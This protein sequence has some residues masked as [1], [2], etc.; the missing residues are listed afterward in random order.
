MARKGRAP[1]RALL[2]LVSKSHPQ[3]DAASAIT[4]GLVLV[5]GRVA[6]NPQSL[7][8]RDASITIR[9]DQPL[10]GEA[11]LAAALTGFGVAVAGRVALDLGAAAGGFTRTL[12]AAG[13]ARVYAVDAGFGQLLG[14]LRRHPAVVVLERTNLADLSRALV[15]EAVGV[16]TSDLSYVALARALPQL[17]GR[18]AFE[19]DADLL[20]VVKPQFELGL[21]QAPTEPA[22][23]AEA[24]AL[25]VRGAERAGWAA[26]GV[27]ESPVR[28]ARGAIEL[29]LHAT[30]V[31]QPVD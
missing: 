25:A 17:E 24:A 4:S 8:R 27:E 1:L 20:A 6:T 30:R 18:V 14:S 10:R 13:A 26:H 3:L 23:R 31:G 5:D 16:L 15:P 11:K 9:R 12:L 7:V 22:H 29:L 19:L 28:G 21:P 2:A